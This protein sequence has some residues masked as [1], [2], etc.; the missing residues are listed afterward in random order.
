MQSE[1]TARRYNNFTFQFFNELLKPKIYSQL[2]DAFNL[3]P[4]EYFD[5]AY[6]L[7][8][9]VIAEQFEGIYDRKKFSDD[10]MKLIH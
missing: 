7:S 8:D 2:S 10:E 6:K 5:Q 9:A 1:N 4:I 3:P